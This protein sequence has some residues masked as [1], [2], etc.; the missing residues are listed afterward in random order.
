MLSEVEGAFP[1]IA[2]VLVKSS[3]DP[4]LQLAGETELVIPH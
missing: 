4:H 2:Q 1:F 3:P